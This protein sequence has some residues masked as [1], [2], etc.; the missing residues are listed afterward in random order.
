MVQWRDLAAMSVGVAR[1]IPS[2][3]ASGDH[4][5]LRKGMACSIVQLGVGIVA[6][7]RQTQSAASNQTVVVKELLDLLLDSSIAGCLLLLERWCQCD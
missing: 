1:D 4:A 5:V 2:G 3:R 6:S 7:Q